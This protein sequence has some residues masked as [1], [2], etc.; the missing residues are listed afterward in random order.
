MIWKYHIWWF[1]FNICFLCSWYFNCV[2][3]NKITYYVPFIWHIKCSSFV[4][5]TA[6]LHLNIELQYKYWNFTPTKPN[7]ID[8]Y[9][10]FVRYIMIWIIINSAKYKTKYIFCNYIADTLPHL[11]FI[12][13]HNNFQLN[14]HT[15]IVCFYLF[16]FI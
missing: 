15:G 12:L 5:F 9:I 13:N 3:V 11:H 1:C 6:E 7:T 16:L 2:H 14:L 10:C 4:A 8:V